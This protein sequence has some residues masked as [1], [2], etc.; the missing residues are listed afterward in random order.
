MN[1][2][3]KRG[4]VLTGG[5]A[6]GAY[7]VGALLAIAEVCKELKIKHPFQIITGSSAGAINSMF[8]AANASH[9]DTGVQR[10]KLL[11]ESIKQG[12]VLC[13]SYH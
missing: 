9:F 10:L 7:Q 12:F 6:R 3:I 5:G 2:K 4:I 11:W 8:M 13:S 1:K